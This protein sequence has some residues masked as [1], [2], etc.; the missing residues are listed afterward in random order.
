LAAELAARTATVDEVD[1][2]RGPTEASE[3]ARPYRPRARAIAAP[4]GDALDRVRRLTEAGRQH[5]AHEI[6]SL[7]PPDA[8][9][10]ILDALSEWNDH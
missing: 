6:V 7:E 8:A 4:A 2:P 9:K 10:R 3:L 1:G 5:T